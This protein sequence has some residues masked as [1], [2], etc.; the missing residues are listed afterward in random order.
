MPSPAYQSSL[1]FILRWEGGYVDHPADPGGRTNK[2]V[3]QSVYDR[4]R[5]QQGLPSRRVKLIEDAEVETI[6]ETGYWLPPGC[7]LLRRQLDLVQ[8]D[9]A[10]NMG[11][12]RAVRFLQAAVGCDV[13]GAFGPRT[14]KEAA[15]CDLGA[16]IEA[17]CDARLAYYRRLA[18][19]RPEL[20]VFLKGWTN[21]VDALK[22]EVG[23]RGFE[24]AVPLDFGD[25]GYIAKVPD[26]GVDPSYDFEGR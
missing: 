22:A 14:A 15:E 25:A 2:G 18:E 26:M 12:G 1:P 19:R 7:D 13:D 16:T 5:T 10:V 24:A 6:Y 3:T 21:R 11:V 20:G 17:Y 8:F 9:T 23:L 4:W